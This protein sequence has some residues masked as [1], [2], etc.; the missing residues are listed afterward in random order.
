[1]ALLFLKAGQAPGAQHLA[2]AR[3]QAQ[4]LQAPPDA[5]QFLQLTQPPLEPRKYR[6]LVGD[7]VVALPHRLLSDSAG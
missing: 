4:R 1:M 3:G 5:A 7:F 6:A 2:I